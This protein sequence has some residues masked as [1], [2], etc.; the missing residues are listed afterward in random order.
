MGTHMIKSLATRQWALALRRLAR[1]IGIS[2]AVFA[3]SN[4]VWVTT[5]NADVS[6]QLDSF[7]NATGGAANVT[8]PVA[9]SG[10]QGGY[11]SGGSLWVRF[12]AQ[13][14]FQ[15]GNLQMPSVKA[16]CGGIDIFTGSFSF[17][18]S[19]QLVAVAKAIANGAEAFLFNLAIK[20]ISSVIGSTLTDMLHQLQQKLNQSL[21]ACQLGA[22]IAG[23]LAGSVGIKN[24]QMCSQIGN[25]QGIF[26]DWA[27]TEQGCG[28]GGQQSSTI[29][30]NNDKTI[31]AGPYNYTWSMLTQKY[32]NFDT[33]FKQYL[34]T[35]VGTIIYQPASADSQGPQFTF[36][37]QGDPA[38]LTALLD[39][40]N[41]AQVYKCDDSAACLNPTQT[42]LNVDTS[43]ALKTRVYNDLL[44]IQA[45]IQNNQTLTTEEIG[46]LG[47]VHIPLYKIM[48]VN[49]AA[50]YGSMGSADLAELA[51]ITSVD[52]LESVVQQFY[53]LV[54]DGQSQ[55]H[56]ADSK[57]LEQWR[58]QIADVS[59]TLDSQVFRNSARL[60]RTEQIVDRTMRIEASLRNTMAPQMAAAL[61]F[62]K[63][64]G[65]R[66][67]Q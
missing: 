53:K 23:G 20:E 67:L 51:E 42:T 12:P 9:Y 27:A 39:G 46:I 14:T 33:D 15:L 60:T 59:K 56:N 45:R 54:T 58:T 18:N 61:Q 21:N 25:S 6:G 31:P 63:A 64:L 36:I 3:A 26:S 49:S 32:P 10:Q 55:F 62:D 30:S 57:T 4:I 5:V 24:Q 47:A 29:K 16:G 38:L 50:T 11:Y 43:K 35:L 1:L 65:Q 28:T 44:D 52:L 34:M 22:D 66:P 17:I 7:F 48:A 37:G 13:Q 2:L 8:G 19:D 40:G 41:G